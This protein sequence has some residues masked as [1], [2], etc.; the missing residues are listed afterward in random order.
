MADNRFITLAI[1]TYDRAVT[2]RK[3]LES[4]GIKVKFENLVMTGV[5]IAS[6]VRVKI[7]ERDLPLALK[8]TESGDSF[9]S[10]KVEMKIAGENGNLLIPVDFSPY[11]MLAVRFGFQ[12]ALKLSLHPVLLH[13]YTTPYF[14]G[15]MMYDSM[16]E[17]DNSLDN[18]LE[19]TE[20]ASDMRKES[21]RMMREFRRKIDQEVEDGKLPEI[22]Y[23]VYVNEGVPED[24]ILDYC[25]MT[26]PS[27]VVM[28]TRGVSKKEADLIGSVTAEVLDSCRVPVFALPENCH[29][30]NIE[31]IKKVVYF[32]NL[33]QHDLMSVD[34]LMRMFDYP[35]VRVT[36]IPVNDRAVN[37][38]AEKVNMLRDY[39]EKNY[40]ASEFRSEIFSP[41]NF[42]DDFEAYLQKSGADL[43][44]V[45]NKKKNIFSR[46]F[47]PGMA[48]KLLFE[49]DMPML[50][51]PV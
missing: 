26:P 15:N 37:R 13:A 5:H 28:S 20:M 25:R 9:A 2:L 27:L 7:S 44:I 4:H 3:I 39:F 30:E 12:V 6:G 43:L 24:V 18:D 46:L 47:N 16:A 51:L 11:S 31:G 42:R 8:I 10:A 17:P 23:S 38:I 19:E 29:L 14:M 50:A 48:H 49:R 45:P 1:H 41:K 35:E 33:D 21:E 36:L 22:G 32:C 40:P 34:T